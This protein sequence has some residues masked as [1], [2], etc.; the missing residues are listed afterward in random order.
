MVMY[1]LNTEGTTLKLVDR[2]MLSSS[3]DDIEAY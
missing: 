1:P 3:S 2:I